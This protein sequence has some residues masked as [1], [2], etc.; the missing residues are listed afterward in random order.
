[1][2]VEFVI[3]V[4]LAVI[5]TVFWY[6]YVREPHAFQQKSKQLRKAV[7]DNRQVFLRWRKV[8]RSRS[9]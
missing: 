7:A 2:C 9:A 5:W 6:V 4:Q 8:W 3:S 1:M